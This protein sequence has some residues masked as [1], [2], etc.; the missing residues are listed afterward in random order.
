MSTPLP[1]DRHE[2]FANEYLV[3]LNAG[4][5]YERAGYKAGGRTADAAAARLLANV[6]VQGR[7]A[8]L[9]SARA[10]RVEVTQDWVI[11][12][13]VDNV[14]RAMQAEE[15]RDREG[16]GIGEFVYAGTVANKA[17]EL[18][19]KH[20]GLFGP[21]GTDDDPVHVAHRV[22]TDEDRRRRLDELRQHS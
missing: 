15:V 20:L 21:K 7:I 13:L 12:R 1:N 10:E 17:L 5:A 16:N 14:E 18:L 3:D 6:N 19:G 9:Q 11:R 22:V 8:A 4:R 2:R